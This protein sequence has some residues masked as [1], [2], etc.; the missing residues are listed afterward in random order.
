M[1]LYLFVALCWSI[2]IGAV[3]WAQKDRTAAILALLGIVWPLVILAALLIG[4]FHVAR[5]AV[6]DR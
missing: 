1:I 3:A 6:F 5:L 4:A 2:A